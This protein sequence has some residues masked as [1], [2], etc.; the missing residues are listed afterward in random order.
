MKICVNRNKLM[1][2]VNKSDNYC[3]ITGNVNIA[4]K[5]KNAT[6][7]EIIVGK[8]SVPC[9]I[10][11]ECEGFILN[12]KHLRKAVKS[13]EGTSIT[14]TDTAITDG[15]RDEVIFKSDLYEFSCMIFK[16]PL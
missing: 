1:K 2:A 15:G 4:F 3:P 10:E 11:G 12:Y 5:K 8:I 6:Y 16:R 13:C 9:L 14:I 7:N